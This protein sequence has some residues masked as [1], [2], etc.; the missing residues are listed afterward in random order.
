MLCL[1]SADK[2]KH[3]YVN[4][5][6]SMNVWLDDERDPN[7]PIIQYKFGAEPSMVWVKTA[8]TAIQI[9]KSGN[10][11]YMSFDHD[12]GPGAGTGYEVAKWVEEQAYYGGIPR[13]T[14]TVHS[15]NPEGSKKI[16]QAMQSA[17]R[18]WREH[19]KEP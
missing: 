4:L 7:D 8:H 5:G 9:L 14:W 2:T 16:V 12:L 6:G 3:C 15:A 10:V 1:T 13:F 18:F 17:E 11:E 19:E